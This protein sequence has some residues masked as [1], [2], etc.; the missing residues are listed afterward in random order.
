MRFR[1]IGAVGVAGLLLASVE[2]GAAQ[3]GAAA[4]VREPAVVIIGASY[5]R[6]WQPERLG[7]LAVINRGV[8]GQRWTVVPL[9][10]GLVGQAFRRREAGLVRGRVVTGSR[11]SWRR[12]SRFGRRGA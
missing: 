12:R 6:G 10:P 1:S 5:A 2:A 11:R 3:G 9:G 7:E 4:A 8:G